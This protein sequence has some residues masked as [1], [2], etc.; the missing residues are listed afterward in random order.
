MSETLKSD[1]FELRNLVKSFFE[2]FVDVIE[3]SENG[4]AFRPVNIGCCR[5]MMTEKLN[6][7][8]AKMRE[9]SGAK[10]PRKLDKLNNW[11]D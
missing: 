4:M 11:R 10:E 3:V 5:C 1:A 8:L 9:L 2:D 6:E 7:T